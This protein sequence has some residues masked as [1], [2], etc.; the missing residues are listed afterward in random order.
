MTNY[1]PGIIKKTKLYFTA[2]R[3]A[4]GTYGKKL[5]AWANPTSS[6]HE[7][8]PQFPVSGIM[9]LM[10]KGYSN[11]CAKKEKKGR[12]YSIYTKLRK[13]HNEYIEVFLSFENEKQQLKDKIV[14]IDVEIKKATD[15][16]HEKEHYILIANKNGYITEDMGA[17]N[18]K[19]LN[20]QVKSFKDTIE[21]LEKSKE[22]IIEDLKHVEKIF[23][24]NLSN[25]RSC[26]P[27]LIAKCEMRFDI[28][29]RKI[30]CIGKFYEIEL[31]YYLDVIER[32]INVYIGSHPLKTIC[33]LCDEVF[34]TK[35]SP[36]LYKEER[37]NVMEIKNIM[38]GN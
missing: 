8:A 33:I 14:E 34:Y 9:R 13:K 1:S 3:D 30:E 11:D 27:A 23:S 35:D 32:K 36:L 24:D 37:E 10:I 12:N 5:N 6:A 22:P 29:C 18:L 21:K 4:N 17:K 19:E 38:Q 16:L 7:K 2:L 31:N 28:Y 26:F 15:R 25:L 20:E